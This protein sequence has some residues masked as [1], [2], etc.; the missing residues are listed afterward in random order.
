MLANEFNLCIDAV[1]SNDNMREE[2][3][4]FTQE[5]S[6]ISW[7][8]GSGEQTHMQDQSADWVIMASSFHWTD[9][10]KSLPEFARVLT[11]GEEVFHC[12]MESAPYS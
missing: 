3:K 4:K 7:H 12:H 9:S 8:E 1:E 5:L 11:R 10:K 6:N 2:G